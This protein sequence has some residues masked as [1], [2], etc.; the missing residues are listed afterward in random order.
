MCR[1]LMS[2]SVTVLFLS[3]PIAVIFFRILDRYCNRSKKLKGISNQFRVF[4]YWNVWV[5]LLQEDFLNFNYKNT[6]EL[7][8]RRSNEDLFNTRHWAKRS[9]QFSHA[10]LFAHWHF[11]W[12]RFFLIQITIFQTFWG[13]R[14]IFGCF[15]AFGWV[16]ALLGIRFSP[17]VP[18]NLRTVQKRPK[19][20]DIELQ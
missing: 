10:G 17:K 15:W 16:R 13:T 2:F 19:N 7:E 14:W 11:F 1:F 18:E 20:Q 12:M 4:I 8:T 6:N 9:G 5:I 3:L